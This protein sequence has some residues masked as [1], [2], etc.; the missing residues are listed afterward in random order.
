M[1]NEGIRDKGESHIKDQGI[2]FDR[3]I[4]KEAMQA[5]QMLPDKASLP[6][7]RVKN[8]A[9]SLPPKEI[10]GYAQPRVREPQ[11]S[12]L[13]KETSPNM[14]G[15][16]MPRTNRDDM[17]EPGIP[18]AKLVHKKAMEDRLMK[19]MDEM[20]A[21]QMV[22]PAG[23]KFNQ[24][25]DT[26]EKYAGLPK[27]ADLENWL[28]SLCYRFA[29][30]QMGGPELDRVRTMLLIEHLEGEALQFYLRHVT[31]VKRSKFDWTF[32][33]VILALY[34]RFVHPLS[35]Q[36]AREE[37]KK[38]KFAANKGV[39][40]FYDVLLEY[41]QN[42]YEWPDE[43]TILEAFLD[44]IP[45]YIRIH[46]LRDK[47]LSPEMH[48]IS[49][50]ISYTVRYED[51]IKTLNYYQK[52]H[53]STTT[54]TTPRMRDAQEAS[55]PLRVRSGGKIMVLQ[56]SLTLEMMKNTM[57]GGG[58]ANKPK[59]IPLTTRLT[60]KDEARVTWTSRLAAPGTK[61]FNCGKEGHFSRECPLPREKQ[62]HVRA[63]HTATPDK[64]DADVSEF[65][66]EQ[67]HCDNA[68]SEQSETEA[69]TEVEVIDSDWYESDGGDDV[70]GLMNVEPMIDTNDG[71]S[72]AEEQHE[73]IHLDVPVD[74]CIGTNEGPQAKAMTEVPERVA[75]A[76]EEIKMR[77][78][79]LR[80]SKTGRMRPQV[81]SEHKMCLAIYT[82]VAGVDAWTLWDS[83]STTM[84][85]TPAF[86]Q[87]ADITVDTLLDPHILQLSTTGSRSSIK[88]GA[89]VRI[90][91]GKL[92]T[93]TYLDIANFDRY[94]MIMGTPFMHQNRVI[95]DFEKLEVRVNGIAI[96]AVKAPRPDSDSRLRQQRITDKAQE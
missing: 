77:K 2:T 12:P 55:R 68:E 18:E 48:S 73:Y 82:N 5:S 42:M 90:T 57:V 40:G 43:Y 71:P 83:G 28:S 22:F 15:F 30:R 62:L 61:C 3:H 27:F 70:M 60:Q 49:D 51:R 44:R 46:L 16:S 63:A 36:D 87:I 20:L 33:T 50:F 58:G 54:D 95:L 32:E 64:G 1:R 35:M 67:E 96:P 92:T 76:S 14:H 72:M 10:P 53:T 26:S 45:E 34:K 88:Y 47:G 13:A 8:E 66:A 24:K 31:N 17:D 56:S 25:M 29:V 80:T 9:T 91:V 21:I 84:G 75:M 93:T 19:L 7:P 85:I 65:E 11:R 38:A 89:D 6:P 78:I 39:Q 79:K 86:A 94:D 23:F 41:A 81:R 37:F 59:E 74:S 4:A 69:Y 52:K